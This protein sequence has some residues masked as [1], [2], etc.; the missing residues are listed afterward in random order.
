VRYALRV[1]CAA[2][3]AAA[4]SDAGA[5]RIASS[6]D[7]GGTSLRYAD[8]LSATG[9][10][11]SP[12]LTVTWPRATI[13]GTASFA[14]L[15][16]GGLSSQGALAG[17]IFTPSAGPFAGEFASSLGGSAH[18]DGTRTGAFQGTARLH[19]MGSAGGVWVGGGAG[20]M[21]DGIVWRNV[22]VADTGAWAR[23][24]S[25]V[26]E[27][28]M[29]PTDVA[30]S[31]RYTDVQ[32]AL[33]WTRGAVEFSATAGT[34]SGGHLPTLGGTAT[35]WGSGNLV[36]WVGPH[37]AVVASGGSYPVDLRQGFPGGKFAALGIRI[38]SRTATPPPLDLS[39]AAQ[40][41]VSAVAAFAVGDAANG[42][43][44]VRV[45]APLAKTVEISGDFTEWGPVTLTRGNDGWWT[46]AVE[47]TPGTHQVNVRADGAAWTVPPGLM[48]IR[49]EFGG[50]VGLL[51]IEK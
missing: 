23:F 11:L 9:A 2:A 35:S 48:A 46:A 42:L 22:R 17:S 36:V 29:T 40:R 24:G 21:S 31:I 39:P 43:R 12:A 14:Q 16:S 20:Q 41:T 18:Q 47:I 8:T 15:S 19:L 37:L 34:R 28:T 30:D 49:D 4:A 44:V 32:A 38:G 45:R 13:A 33:D 6:L 10:V 5:Q 27:L 50:S 3:F 1:A 25:T 51:L 26:L 7:A